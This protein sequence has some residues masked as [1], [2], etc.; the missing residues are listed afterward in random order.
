MK[1]GYFIAGGLLLVFLLLQFFQP[2]KNKDQEGAEA[3]MLINLSAPEQLASLLQT[4]CYDCHSNN[5]AYPWYSRIS[6]LSWYLR[7]HIDKGKEALNFSEF[8]EKGRAG[9]IGTL[10]EICEVVEAGIMPLQS[11]ILV[12]WD[13]AL[14]I[15]Q[16]GL[17]CSWAE[18]E[19]HKLLHPVG[20]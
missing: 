15:E 10:L 9:K 19:N 4:S 3:D 16:V 7:K 5:T 6:P 11:Y 8:G 18:E 14:S 1:K 12:H 13:A 2:Q 17:L 20:E